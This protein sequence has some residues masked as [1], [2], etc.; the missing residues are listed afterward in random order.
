MQKQ[1]R[2]QGQQ[3]QAIQSYLQDLKQSAKI[4]DRRKAINAAVRRQSA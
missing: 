3:Q 2:S 1:Q 4:D